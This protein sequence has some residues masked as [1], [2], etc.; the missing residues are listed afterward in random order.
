M[1]WP[2]WNF[3]LLFHLIANVIGPLWND[4]HSLEKC[5]ADADFHPITALEFLSQFNAEIPLA[6]DKTYIIVTAVS[7]LVFLFLL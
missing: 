2:V 5:L 3:H 7:V 6:D 4:V 1:I